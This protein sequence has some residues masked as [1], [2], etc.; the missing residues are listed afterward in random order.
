[1]QL[2][3]FAKSYKSIAV[4]TAPPGQLILMLYDGALRFMANAAAGFDE[5]QFIRRNEVIHN[6]LVKVEHI[7][8]ELQGVLDMSVEGGFPQRM[9]ALYGFMLSQI[10]LA[11]RAKQQDPI[12]VVERILGE[13]RDAWARMLEQTASENRAA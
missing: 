2:S 6:N 1:M 3:Q 10:R 5:T 9:Y 4:T 11:N 13:I 12:R 8:Q 7:L